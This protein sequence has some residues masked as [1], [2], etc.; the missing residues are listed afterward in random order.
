MAPAS[1][2]NNRKKKQP[3]GSAPTDNASRDRGPVAGTEGASDDQGDQARDP[4][5]NPEPIVSRTPSQAAPDDALAN[6]HVDDDANRDPEGEYDSLIVE[7]SLRARD[8]D[9]PD[10]S[11]SSDDEG[12]RVQS[13]SKKVSLSAS[14]GDQTRLTAIIEIAEAMLVDFESKF[15]TAKE[16]LLAVNEN[17]D[18]IREEQRGLKQAFEDLR[19]DGRSVR[20]QL[21]ETIGLRVETPDEQ[22]AQSDRTRTPSDIAVPAS[23]KGKGRAVQFSP[24]TRS[25]ATVNS[26]T[27]GQYWGVCTS[28]FKT[29]LH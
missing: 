26:V 16:H 29:T 25:P 20:Q 27:T 18:R 3:V 12:P 10:P 28:R 22:L 4:V 15:D 23:G 19:N 7:Q 9:D 17:A 24:S 14:K 11:G 13:K 2:K 1:N 21:R 5:S 6:A 8:L